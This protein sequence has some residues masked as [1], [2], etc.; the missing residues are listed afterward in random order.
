MDKEI[1]AFEEYEELF[2]SVPVD[3]NAEMVKE[4]ASKLRE[5][6]GLSGIEA[7]A[8]KKWLLRHW[9]HHK[10]CA[11]RWRNGLN[12]YAMSSSPGRPTGL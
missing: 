2:E 1:T 3:C 10:F 9:P 5:G 8:L 12:G 6:A 4:V 7:I 11:R